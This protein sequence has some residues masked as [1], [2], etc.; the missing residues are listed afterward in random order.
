MPDP[1][2]LLPSLSINV[3]AKFISYFK[4]LRRK[5]RRLWSYTMPIIS[6]K[7][8]LKIW[9]IKSTRIADSMIHDTSEWLVIECLYNTVW[10]SRRRVRELLKVRNTLQ[11]HLLTSSAK[12]ITDQGIKVHPLLFWIKSRLILNYET[13]EKKHYFT[14]NSFSA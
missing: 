1:K 13:V 5:L 9:K 12:T 10:Y 2:S 3:F 7:R 11:R 14:K 8:A 6:F 4:Q